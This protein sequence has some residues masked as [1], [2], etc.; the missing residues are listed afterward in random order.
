M[1]RIAI[2]SDIHANLPALQ[3]VMDDIQ[4]LGD[5]E[6]CWMLGDAIGYGPYP[7]E[8]MDYLLDDDIPLELSQWLAGNHDSVAVGLEYPEEGLPISTMNPHA[9]AVITRHVRK[10]HNTDDKYLKWLHD[11]SP[12]S[13]VGN[14]FYLGHGCYQ[15]NNIWR[16]LTKYVKNR[17]VPDQIEEDYQ[18]NQDEWQSGLDAGHPVLAI[19]GHWH[20]PCLWKRNPH[21]T[22]RSNTWEAEPLP[23]DEPQTLHPGTLYHLK[24]GSVGWSRDPKFPCPT[25]IVLEQVDE[26]NIKIQFRI[27]PYD[28]EQVR[29]RAKKL[30][31]PEAIWDLENKQ[32]QLPVCNESIHDED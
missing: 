20:I 25:Y 23:I 27:V 8:T 16:S 19:Y 3:A 2:F 5:I 13:K 14:Q 29:D 26:E 21:D 32:C 10:L 31:Y 4:T 12:I 28:S 7:V 30:L 17:D 18:Q 22:F 9:K 24:P 11:C 15:P 6:T 1:P